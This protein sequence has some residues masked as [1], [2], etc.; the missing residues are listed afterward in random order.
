MAAAM[1][2]SSRGKLHGVLYK[3][4][5]GDYETL[6]ISE[7]CTHPNSL[8]KDVYAKAHVYPSALQNS[9]K[10]T[11]YPSEALATVFTCRRKPTGSGLTRG[12]FPSKRYLSNMTR[13]AQEAGLAPE[14]I[15]QLEATAGTWLF[16]I[17]DN[18]VFL[19]RAIQT[20]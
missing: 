8:Y 6:R 2:C 4:S 3:L 19:L 13:G 16:S 7:G 14:Y 5:R 11:E 18:R 12:L 20:V 9:S 17:Y 15:K 1:P 10:K